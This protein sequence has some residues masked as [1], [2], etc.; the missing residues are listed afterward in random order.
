[1]F[2]KTKKQHFADLDNT[3]TTAFP[4][5]PPQYKDIWIYWNPPTPIQ[6]QDTVPTPGSDEQQGVTSRPLPTGRTL[7][8]TQFPVT[9]RPVSTISL[10]PATTFTQRVQEK[11]RQQLAETILQQKQRQ[12]IQQQD[13]LNAQR[14][15]RTSGAKFWNGCQSEA[16]Y[17]IVDRTQYH[18][19]RH[20][21]QKN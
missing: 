16:S 10:R 1:M 18:R 14:I 15:T 2:E 9:K 6:G 19:F 17:L 4:Q 5:L 11:Q 7:P 13:Q 3:A 21:T 8:V 12:A 20:Y